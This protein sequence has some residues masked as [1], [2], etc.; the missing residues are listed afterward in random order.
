MIIGFIREATCFLCGNGGLDVF[1]LHE[2]RE[3]QWE[4]FCIPC[5]ET[6]ELDGGK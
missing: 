3:G 2:I 1:E 6:L 4:V 5:A